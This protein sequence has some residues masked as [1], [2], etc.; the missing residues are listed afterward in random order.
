V[1]LKQTINETGHS[2][3]VTL[4][5]GDILTLKLAGAPQGKVR[6]AD[7]LDETLIVRIAAGRAFITALRGCTGGTEEH[8]YEVTRYDLHRTAVEERE[9][10]RRQAGLKTRLDG[11]KARAAESKQS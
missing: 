10:A 5:E 11:V 6:G 9:A 2:T 8:V 4:H 3:D 7:D 1:E